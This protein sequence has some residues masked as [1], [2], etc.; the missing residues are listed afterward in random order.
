[1][2]VQ[3]CWRRISGGGGVGMRGVHQIEQ[4]PQRLL[5]WTLV[6]PDHDL[7]GEDVHLK[8]SRHPGRGDPI[9][10][11]DG[12]QIEEALV[13]HREIDDRQG[14]AVTLK[15]FG[16]TLYNTDQID[17]ARESWKSALAIFTDLNDPLAA[18]VRAC[19]EEFETACVQRRSTGP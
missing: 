3:A 1:M 13:A 4:G 15:A 8:V 16:A 12:E 10:V 9:E 6:G 5:R 17:R 7:G 18:A 19:L 2:V 11:L 14:E